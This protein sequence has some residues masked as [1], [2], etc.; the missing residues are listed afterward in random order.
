VGPKKKKKL[1]LISI[2]QTI[3]G[4]GKWSK[5]EFWRDEEEE[6]EEGR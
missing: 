5:M 3:N 2:N 6:V 4:M 1:G